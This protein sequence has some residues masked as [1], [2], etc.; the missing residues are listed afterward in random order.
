MNPTTLKGMRRY[1]QILLSRR[2]KPEAFEMMKLI[3]KYAAPDH[4]NRLLDVPLLDV[5]ADD[6]G[7][8]T[9]NFEVTDISEKQVQLLATVEPPEGVQADSEHKKIMLGPKGTWFVPVQV[10]LGPDAKPG[11][12][13]VFLRVDVSARSPRYGWGIVRKLGKPDVERIV[14]EKSNVTYAAGALDFDLDR[15]LTVVYGKDCTPLELE[16]A[17]TLF[18]TLES[19]T[20]RVVEIFQD[21]QL[22]QHGQGRILISVGALGS[23]TAPTVQL[24]G[25][26]LVVTG[27]TPE[28]TAQAAMDLTLRYWKNAK[29]SACRRVGL[30]E[31]PSGKAGVK[32]DL[33]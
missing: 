15:P 17:W 4:P 19:A 29:D 23:F 10:A 14:D 21:D 7:N 3:K 27:K 5:E 13:H 8:A 22:E 16:S 1:E 28:Q 9:L 31:Q 2:P 32:T 6:Q 12:Y 24:D 11:F 20:G 30:V 18:I 25:D 33:E 26:R